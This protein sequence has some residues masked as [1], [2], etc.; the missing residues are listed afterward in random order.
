MLIETAHEWPGLS[1][2]Y[3][4]QL[5]YPYIVGTDPYVGPLSRPKHLG[6]E[7]CLQKP[8]QQPHH[9]ESDGDEQRRESF[10]DEV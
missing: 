2:Q 10:L 5:P 6:D 7:A 1:N 9:G 3:F 4:M 8:D